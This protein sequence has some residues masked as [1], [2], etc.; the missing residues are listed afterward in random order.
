MILQE[1]RASR[2]PRSSGT[3]LSREVVERAREGM[4]TQFE[5]QRGLPVQ[6]LVKHFR[7]KAANG[8]SDPPCARWCASRSANLLGDHRGAGQ[9]RRGLLPQRA[10]L[11]R[12]QTK[13]RVLRG[14]SQ[15][16]AADGSLYLGAAETAIG[17]T[18]VLAARGT[19]R[20]VYGLAEPQ[21]LSA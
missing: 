4:F 21:R 8:A 20:G 3:D 15:Q 11:F 7:R 5:V 1:L 17:I 16:L 13:G 2:M 14:L 6:M 19:E 12:P 9:V 18:N 10:D